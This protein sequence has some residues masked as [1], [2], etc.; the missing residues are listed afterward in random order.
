[1]LLH[2]VARFCNTAG[3]TTRIATSPSAALAWRFLICC[4]PV[5]MEREL[6]GGRLWYPDCQEANSDLPQ[7]LPENFVDAGAP[8]TGRQS[9]C[10]PCSRRC[11]AFANPRQ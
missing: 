9:P 7:A 1:M 4:M 10:S 11:I 6:Y 8:R 2:C 5:R 3:G